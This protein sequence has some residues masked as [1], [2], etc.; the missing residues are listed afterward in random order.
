MIK[1]FQGD[2]RFLSNFYPSEIDFEFRGNGFKGLMRAA[3]VEHAYQAQKAANS[4]DALRIVGAST[5]GWAK[6][7]GKA[8]MLRPD[9]DAIKLGVMEELLRI[10]FN[11]PVLAKMLLATGDHELVEGNWWN[12]TYWGVCKGVGQNNLGKLLMEIREE[13]REGA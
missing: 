12:D 10:K 7:L 1:E 6:K 3:T 8:I 5:P 11:N 9:W 4:F 2:Y 13:M